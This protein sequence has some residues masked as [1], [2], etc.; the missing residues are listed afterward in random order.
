MWHVCVWHV[1]LSGC[2]CCDIY[3]CVCVCV[4]RVWRLGSTRLTTCSLTWKRA[5]S[6]WVRPLPFLPSLRNCTQL[7]TTNDNLG[8]RQSQ[9][10]LELGWANQSRV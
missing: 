4:E 8:P 10:S 7:H 6:I 1:R 2:L 3:V 9:S 5:S